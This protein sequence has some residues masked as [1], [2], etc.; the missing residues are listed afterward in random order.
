MI[1]TNL[2][3]EMRKYLAM[4]NISLIASYLITEEN[5]CSNNYVTSK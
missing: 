1:P 4:N 3:H 2:I 5:N